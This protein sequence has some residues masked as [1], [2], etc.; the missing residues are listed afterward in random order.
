MDANEH[1][2]KRFMCSPAEKLG[3]VVYRCTYQ[4]DEDW[5][6]FMEYL[7]AHTKWQLDTEGL[8]DL[9]SRLDCTVQSDPDLGDASAEEVRKHARDRC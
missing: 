3:F 6:K 4:S 5:K 2:R 8:G 1:L 9:C 7:A